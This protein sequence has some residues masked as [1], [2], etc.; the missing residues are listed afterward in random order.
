ERRPA[1]ADVPQRAAGLRQGDHRP[2]PAFVEPA[3]GLGGAGE[4]SAATELPAGRGL[5]R[6]GGWSGG[7]RSELSAGLLPA[8]PLSARFPAG[9]TEWAGLPASSLSARFP[10]ET[11]ERAGLP[12]SSLSAGLPAGPLSADPGEEVRQGLADRTHRPPH[13]RADRRWP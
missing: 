1:R 8:R 2:G 7:L 4:L 9:A 13:P 10:A 11:A 6:G 12:A 3:A 5:G